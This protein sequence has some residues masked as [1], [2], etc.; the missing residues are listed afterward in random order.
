MTATVAGDD[1]RIRDLLRSAPLIDGHN[2]LLWE[3]RQAREKAPG[4]A[5]PDLREPQPRWMTDLPR[6]NAGAV[7]GQFWSVYV[8]SDLP[9]DTAV[10]R[11][12]EQIDAMFELARTYPD[13]L[14]IARSADDVERIASAGRVASMIG[15]IPYMPECV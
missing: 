5:A 15:K 1:E 12:L 10:T 13:R 14:E 6:L 4:D 11:T 8:P 3:L 9:G 7:G 2:D